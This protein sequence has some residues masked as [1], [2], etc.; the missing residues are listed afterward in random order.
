[1]VCRYFPFVDKLEHQR[2]CRLAMACSRVSGPFLYISTE[3]SM[4]WVGASSTIHQG[5]GSLLTDFFITQS[6]NGYVLHPYLSSAMTD[7]LMS[8]DGRE[9]KAFRDLICSDDVKNLPKALTKHIDLSSQD[10]L[11][12]HLLTLFARTF[13]ARMQGKI[14]Y[15]IQILESELGKGHSHLSKF[16]LASLF[17]EMGLSYE[18]KGELVRAIEWYNRGVQ[19]EAGHHEACVLFARMFMGPESPFA[20]AREDVKRDVLGMLGRS[21][22]LFH[23]DLVW[24]ELLLYAIAA[25]YFYLDELKATA[26]VYNRIISEPKPLSAVGTKIILCF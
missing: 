17:T 10:T 1:M 6:Y 19:T 21:L 5:G 11:E 23:A 15:S 25:S 26:A 3:S 16:G 24:S 14:D 7:I 13:E 8:L 18:A 2:S 12:P 20:L 9:A 4:S 22:K